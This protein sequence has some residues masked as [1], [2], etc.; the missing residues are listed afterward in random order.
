MQNDW[1]EAAVR[2]RGH[3][4]GACGLIDFSNTRVSWRRPIHSYAKVQ[5]LISALIRNRGV[6]ANKK[7]AGC[8]L[9]LGC[10]PNATPDFCNLDY[11]WHPGVDVCW[12][13]T[14]GLPFADHYI[15][16]IFTEHMLEH[17]P[18]ADALTLLAECRRILRIGGVLRVVVPDG[19]LYLSEYAKHVA[20]ETAH[21]P[22]AD[23]DKGAF[24]I[25]TPIVSLNR[26]FRDHGHQ[27]IWDYETLR[28][29]LLRCGF[30]NVER[31]SFG[32]GADPRLLRDTE[33]RAVE[34]LYVEAN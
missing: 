25:A 32:K 34:S 4:E 26:I 3:R 31:R 22:Y 30:M 10:G 29:A 13:V 8:Y 20:G 12:D 2:V 33:G 14:R 11:T 17:L 24:P 7:M 21:M 6:F 23:G 15:G 16:G 28:L 1:L 27:F 5:W 18:F 9:D 19:Q